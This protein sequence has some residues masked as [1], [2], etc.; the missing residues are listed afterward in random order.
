VLE[1]SLD[2]LESIQREDEVKNVLVKIIN[3]VKNSGHAK[4]MVRHL[5]NAV[6]FHEQH[7]SKIKQKSTNSDCSMEL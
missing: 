7:Y 4:A 6:E 1:E 3:L 2:V 5:Q